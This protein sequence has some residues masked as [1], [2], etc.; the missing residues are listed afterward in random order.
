MIF[1]IVLVALHAGCVQQPPTGVLIGLDSSVFNINPVN[2]TAPI[3]A[4]STSTSSHKKLSQSVI[5]GVAVGGGVL[6]VILAAMLFVCIRKRM[7]R[8][9][10]A[11]FKSR[12]D[13]RYGA[14][15]ITVPIHGAYID[16][17]LTKLSQPEPHENFSLKRLP[18]TVVL[19]MPPIPEPPR[20]YSPR[21]PEEYYY[22]QEQPFSK[23]HN[24]PSHLEN[25]ARQFGLT[26]T[27][28]SKEP[29]PS[30]S[31][32][33]S[34]QPSHEHSPVSAVSQHSTSP[35][36]NQLIT[37][38]TG[39]SA[40]TTASKPKISPSSGQIIS[41]GLPRAPSR[42]ES[43]RTVASAQDVRRT[44]DLSASRNRGERSQTRGEN[45]ISGIS[46]PMVE[47]ATRYE[48]E[49]ELQRV[50]EQEQQYRMGFLSPAQESHE[51]G[52]S[53]EGEEMWP[54]NY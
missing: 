27:S 32:P 1:C 35:F 51:R 38:A 42:T 4:P 25:V 3:V 8:R 43:V 12:L 19:Q 37:P 11:R 30:Y 50:R 20:A 44:R 40:S 53:S 6:L 49:Q 22:A 16:P 45:Q 33:G 15:T 10:N 28:N 7:A 21:H 2:I 52:N 9:K 48:E 46:G 14:E 41:N 13:G 23:Q 39:H 29:S 24:P 5:I 47:V 31:P 18:P 54:G 17:G 34:T 36:A 26:K